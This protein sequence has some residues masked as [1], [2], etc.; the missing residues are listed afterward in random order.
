ME[1]IQKLILQN[2]LSGN[3]SEDQARDMVRVLKQKNAKS[4]EQIAIIGMSV[5][6]PQAK[7]INEYWDMISNKV[8]CVC[9]FPENRRK[10]IDDFLEYQRV[11]ASD[12]KY[13]QMAFLEEIDKF[14]C[15]F[16]K[17][18]PKEAG[19]MDP[20]QRLFLQTAW[21]AVEDAGYGGD[22]LKG[23][24]TGVYV[25]FRGDSDYKRL[26]LDTQPEAFSVAEAGN[27]TSVIASR[28]A[29][30]LDLKG[31]SIVVNTACSSSLVAI[32]CACQGI[33]SGD[34][35]MAIAGAVKIILAPFEYENKL[36]IESSD[37]RTKSFDDS[38]DGTGE[39]EGVASLVLKPLSKALKDG[40]SIY[41]VIKGSAINQD[42]SSNGI[43]APN[44]KAQAEVLKM[45]W[46]D[47]K[48]EPETIAYIEAHGTGTKIGDPIEIDGITSAFRSYTN[49]NGFCAVSSVKTNLGH[50]DTAAGVAGL[51]KAVLALKNKKLPPLSFFNSPNRA[52]NLAESPVYIADKLMDWDTEGYP[53]RC[54][55]S[56]F[57]LSGTN[58]HLVLEEA[59]S[60]KA[61]AVTD[62]LNVLTVSAKSKEALGL[63]I[64]TY[65]EFFRKASIADLRNICYT[66][67][68]GRGHYKY[69]IAMCLDSGESRQDIIDKLESVK[70]D[71]NNGK[72]IF[73][74]EPKNNYP[75]NRDSREAVE[76]D[77][78]K[79]AL[80]LINE[81]VSTG[82]RDRNLLFDICT[83]YTQGAEF[84]WKDLYKGED[85]TKV[86]LPVYPFAQKRCW[87]QIDNAGKNETFK[88]R[89]SYK[90]IDHPL[91]DR[92]LVK[93]IN[94]VIFATDF[95]IDRHWVLSEHS[96][97]GISAVPG[98]TYLEIAVQAAK[99]YYGKEVASVEDVQFYKPLIVGENETVS[100]H[101][102]IREQN[103]EVFF[104]VASCKEGNE[105]DNVGIW[106]L[107][108]T[109]KLSLHKLESPEN[110]NMK[111]LFSRLGVEEA[112]QFD[113]NQK[114]HFGSRWQ[115][116]KSIRSGEEE[117]LVYIE[118][119]QQLI[120]EVDKYMLHPAIL[121]NATALGISSEF[122]YLPFSYKKIEIFKPI[123]A[124][125]YVYIN[126]LPERDGSKEIVTH[127]LS[128][129]NT[130][131]EIVV[132]IHGFTMK[133][134]K[135]ISHTIGKNK[136]KDNLFFKLQWEEEINS[137]AVIEEESK[138]IL[139]IKDGGENAQRILSELRNGQSTIIE[140]DIGTQYHRVNQNLYT[141]GRG[142]DDFAKL[143]R[144]TMGDGVTQILYLS[145]LT[146]NYSEKTNQTDCT[147]LQS[148]LTLFYLTRALVNSKL[149]EALDVVLISGYANKV[150]GEEE[151]IISQNAALFGYGKVV[152]QEYPNL[153]VRCIDID[154]NM[155]AEE[156][157]SEI[158]TGSKNF[159]V[160]YRNGKRYVEIFQPV[161]EAE[162]PERDVVLNKKGVYIITG[163]ISGIGLEIA[164]YL[165]SK[166]NI[167]LALLSRTELPER[168]KW[169]ELVKDKENVK[170]SKKIK[171]LLELESTGANIEYCRADVTN[172]KE[173]SDVINQ[174]R[175]QYTKIN[176]IIHSAG[177]PGAGLIITKNEA[178][179]T[180][181]LA[182]KMIGTYNLDRA[183][184]S[185]ELEFFVLFSSIKSLLGGE[186]Q[187]DYVAANAYLDA[188]TH[189]RNR[190]GKRTL[191]INWPAWKE[192]GM[193][194]DYGVNTDNVFKA[195]S[196]Q[197][198]IEA[199]GKVLM[200]DMER[201]IIGELDYSDPILSS[202]QKMIRMSKSLKL[203]IEQELK[204]KVPVRSSK[205][206]E[207]IHSFVLKGKEDEKY[208][209]LENMVGKIWTEALGLEEINIYDDFYGM[210]G[211]SILAINIVSGIKNLTNYDIN[212]SDFFDN[213]SVYDFARFIETTQ[214][215]D[216]LS[217][218]ELTYDKK[219]LIPITEE[220]EYY[221]VSSG[222]RRMYIMSQVDGETTNYNIPGVNTIEGEL[223]RKH[224][225]EVFK[226][227]IQRHEAFRTT[228]KVIDDEPMQ[229]IH[230]NVDFTIEY[231][232]AQESQVRDVIE[233]FIRPFD[234]KRAPLIRVGLISL[235]KTKHILI[236]DIHHIVFDGSSMRILMEEFFT[237]YNRQKLPE[238]LL[239]Y[240]DFCEWE[241]KLIKSGNI[242]KQEEYWL[243]TFKGT[244]PQ[245]TMPLDYKRARVQTFNGDTINFN[246]SSDIKEKISGL[247]KEQNITLNILFF[248]MFALLINKY[249][250]QKDIVIGSSVAGRPYE[251]LKDIIGMFVNSIAIRINI[252]T[253]S[254]IQEFLK[255]SRDIIV[256]AYDNQSYPFDKLVE[257]LSSKIDRSRNPL[258]DAML[259][260]HNEFDTNTEDGPEDIRFSNYEFSRK[261]STLDFKMDIYPQKE[262]GF[263]CVLEY[264]VDLYKQETMDTFIKHFI[265]LLEDA[266]NNPTKALAEINLFTNEERLLIEQKR[267]NN[268]AEGS[269]SLKLAVSSTF[270]AE[271]ILDYITWWCK[272]FR[273]PVELEFAPYN[274][275]FQELLNDSS[276]ISVNTG[277]NLLLIRFE[278]WIRDDTSED[279][280]KLEKLE[281][282]FRELVQLLENKKKSIPYFVGI[283]PVSTHLSL[284]AELVKHL[285]E[286]NRRW[287]ETLKN[288]KNVYTADFNLAEEIYDIGEIFDK[289]TDKAG[290]IPFT[291]EY[292]AVMGTLVARKIC[293][294]KKQNF[295]V[296]VLD[297][298]NTLWRGICG[299]GTEGE[300]D[301]AE[302][303]RAL[304]SFMLQKRSEG[305]LLALC[306]KNNEKDVWKVFDNNKQMILKQEHFA[307]YRINWKNKS[308]N[309][310][311]MAEELNLGIDSFI[312]IDDN[313]AECAEVM[314][315]CPQ[316][317]TLQLPE[318]QNQIEMY[319]RHVWAFDK[320]KVTKEDRE[321]AQMYTAEKN[322][323]ES[324]KEISSLDDFLE[325]LEIKMSMNIMGEQETDRVS[326]LTQRTNQFNLST[327]RRTEKE[328]TEITLM[329][330]K[331]C[332]VIKVSDRFGDYGLV[333]VV[334]TEEK[335]K[336]LFV[337]TLLLSCRVLGKGIEDSILV[338]LAKECREQGIDIMETEYLF[339]EKNKPV[340]EFLERTGWERAGTTENSIKFRIPIDKIS[341]RAKYVD[342]YFN[343]GYSDVRFVPEEKEVPKSQNRENKEAYIEV[344]ATKERAGKWEVHLVNQEKLL[345]RE[346][347]SPLMKCTV[348][349][350][351]ELPK[352]E[353]VSSNPAKTEYVPPRNKVE[354]EICKIWQTVLNAETV[355]IDDTFFDLGG[356]SL[357][358][359]SLISKIHN[360]F[361]VE[362]FLRDIFSTPTVREM[363]KLVEKLDKSFYSS[364]QPVE[365]KE[366]YALSSAQRRMYIINK[367]EGATTNYNNPGVNVI[368]GELD[369][370]Q[371]EEVFKVLIQRHES[372]RT[373]F[374][375][376]DGEPVQIIHKEADFE[377]EH[378]IAEESEADR[379]IQEFIRPFD[380]ERAPLLRVG[381]V[382]LS[383][384][385]HILICDMHHIISDGVSVNILVNEFIQLL[386]GK[387]LPV[388][389]LHYKD[390]SEWQDKLIKSGNMSKQEEYWHNTFKGTI[391]QL[392]M[393]LDYKRTGVQT[394]NG[395]TINFNISSDIEYKISGLVKEQNITLNIL[396][397]SMFALLINKY[398]SQKDIV[399]GS[400]VAGRPY[401]ELN[402]II[403]MFI[404]S[405]AIRI[406]IDNESNIQEFLKHSR[407]IVV[408]AYDNQSY[409]FDKLVE[410][411]SSK[412]DR[413]RNPLFDA[414][415]IYHNEFDTNTE[416]GPED[417][418]FSNY[419][420]SR[421]TSTL[422]FKMDIY[423]QKEGGF[424]C[425]LEY[426]I[427]LYKQETM[428]T[429]IKHFIMLLED[430]VN[431]PTKA[432]AEMDVFTNEERLLI[433]QKR[434]NNES[435]GSNSLKLAVS[436]TFTAEPISD[437][438]TW[439]CKE[440]R[441]P[442]ELEFAPYNQV[443]QELLNDSSL[444]S[445]NT[446]LNLLLIRFEDWIRDDTSE[447][448]AKLE[449]LE[450]NFR[451]LVQLLENKKKSIPYFVGIFPVSTHLS[452][453]AEL[454]K[455]LE[456]MNRRW[457]KTLKNIKNVYTV[458]FNL[459]EELYDIEEIFDKSTDK[460]GHIPFTDEYFAVMGTMVARKI[461][462]WK[463]QTFKVIVFDC[464]NTLWR[465]ICDEGTETEPY[466]ALQN[467]MLQKRSEGM[468]LALCSKNNEKDVWK[469]F[470]NNEQM[471][472]KQ[473]HFAAYRINLKNKSQ[474][475]MEM[476]EELNLGMDSFIYIDDNPTECAEVMTNCPQV[477][478][479]QLPEN[480]NQIEMYLRHVWA[481]DS[482]KE[483]PKAQNHEYK[484]AS[485][486]AA[487][488][489]RRGA[490]KWE[491]H[492]VNEEKLLHREYMSPLMKCT[493]KELLEL[494]KYERMSSNPAKTEYVPPRN[495]VEE[496]ICKIW[497]IVLNLETV[498]IDDT[499][500]DLGGN[501]L[502]AI[503]LEVEMEKAGFKIAGYDVF[504]LK[505]VR[506][507][508]AQ[509][510]SD[511]VNGTEIK[512][513]DNMSNTLQIVSEVASQEILSNRV[514]IDGIKP[515][516]EIYYKNCFYNSAF[517]VIE[518][519]GR[520]INTF[521]IND[522]PVFSYDEDSTEMK[523]D[524]EYIQVKHI[525]K[526]L[527]EEGIM[528]E[529]KDS[530]ENIVKD[531]IKSIS[532]KRPVVIW[533]D[534]F[535]ESIRPEMYQK[536]HWPHTLLVYGYDESQKVFYII[537]HE[538]RDN[539]SYKPRT[540]G[541]E[542]IINSYNGYLTNFS[543]NDATYYEFYY[544]SAI[545]QEKTDKDSRYLYLSYITANKDLIKEHLDYLNK[546][547]LDLEKI[548]L[549][550]SVLD[551]SI[552]WL[553]DGINNIVNIK[554]VEKY[555]ITNLFGSESEC[556]STFE[557]I[558]SNWIFT[559]GAVAK[560]MY[561]GVYKQ[562]AFRSLIQSVS[563]FYE[564]E[565]KYYTVLFQMGK[566]L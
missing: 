312:F 542:D 407:D 101:T 156:L 214:S 100:A 394:F 501:S 217:S 138:T 363:A 467:F 485:V 378:I 70:L 268:E 415:L 528:V 351:L 342:C 197:E 285:E 175:T 431:N 297:C 10:D 496:E 65:I 315:N 466:I 347:M 275:V 24:K 94:E 7:D 180:K 38:S 53:R 190:L 215:S 544:N 352:Y 556:C 529:T 76:S 550:K 44:P 381:L 84:D 289:S 487:S 116:M 21:N 284:S 406:D 461:C 2:V 425:V 530:S 561:S 359:V 192:T 452:L 307:A 179:I 13:R 506:Q 246:I 257:K 457:K 294:W 358:A 51:V 43:T 185:D 465:G 245:L 456:E 552:Q 494:P 157:F 441:E 525:E 403:G 121:D 536:S 345:H 329:S 438:I 206:K 82:K 509:F 446:G 109:G 193:A 483:V 532:K 118:P 27:L 216:I 383:D 208:T 72:G 83:L 71:E 322:R 60:A 48:I 430:A 484:V 247:V 258:F 79:R 125:S 194:A 368:T 147:S 369:K 282:N 224:L 526:L 440:F 230:K 263:S 23:T 86:N 267:K 91:L 219:L 553:L 449:K 343:S 209:E 143:I 563:K 469:V 151:A 145:K 559:R 419:E 464:D 308:Q 158:N 324:K 478:T 92:C 127:N 252:D 183:T 283:F 129:I 9:Q 122:F 47:A 409:P 64:D 414:M 52:L 288:I 538:H 300:V 166:E 12:I 162:I 40:D 376:V 398:S 404:N 508:A 444:I 432:L 463:K 344:A 95:N 155:T 491:V 372:F 182:S 502:L 8:N 321:R 124:K 395:D 429:F 205:A 126:Q 160:S 531:I 448:G 25:G 232:D 225:E 270:T 199:F 212:I 107:H 75:H 210:G 198:G 164:K 523:L 311:E 62:F 234:L 149:T 1:R 89:E 510:T 144:D 42:G 254:K 59:P 172:Y 445:V 367:M 389:L 211:D 334:I 360:S 524:V 399:I 135:D 405:I 350:L 37:A 74:G 61:N 29:Y 420:F 374:K 458:D 332:Y 546:F 560:Y 423:P 106:N 201:V 435:Q 564:L 287:K 293:A 108:A 540:I 81:F 443:F 238:L 265:M 547:T 115:C 18:S 279:G 488:A 346:Y 213:P 195:I 562:Q 477:L 102:C 259:I 377:I 187:S 159:L 262:G 489:I 373:S 278:D 379:V 34:C 117:V 250:S 114:M 68:T 292:F 460:A 304:Q 504:K 565:S 498:G 396:F 6:F 277:L 318:N 313:P 459:A 33:R 19:L 50:L 302:P 534:C 309:I 57:G 202:E 167:N 243:N 535:Y 233:E 231:I 455:H 66:S 380:L 171:A 63:L 28:I 515:F 480:Q 32:H 200:S 134:V 30:I 503:K 410:K 15:E 442:V 375:V 222:Q 241:N 514:L 365:E 153:K 417:I 296:I 412:I 77:T 274:Q 533:I 497:Q 78:L 226:V 492:V 221:H 402:D 490:E 325:G 427:D 36:G 26:I 520:S 251:E 527:E 518:L 337:E 470:D 512:T 439:W 434:K 335:G 130:E 112:F 331:K 336:S 120:D 244:I 387:S 306:S 411:L 67:N 385:K 450:R 154:D 357:K 104:S 176:G 56:S 133:K 301:V 49:K 261:T 271:P 88:T 14:D 354:E 401:E 500:F 422:D 137:G 391:P 393:P 123:P 397:F 537:E 468:L 132:K 163:G 103:G 204:K 356:N 236:H 203:Q 421:K 256:A 5:K 386:N 161:I 362:L 323:Q 80:T 388:P 119:M 299:E 426:N 141:V 11:D 111:E 85:N 35:D 186:G 260:Y 54:G 364:I 303:Y 511:N 229:V 181:V 69:R 177:V 16:F 517:P 174:L 99:Y 482:L 4:E 269:N 545:A 330:N 189:Y 240:K 507:L 173:V 165:S 519:Y 413:S 341:A 428:D 20:N 220:K 140:A 17:I 320:L 505:T 566:E 150:T 314:T 264:N 97:G 96:I 361:S 462:A 555:L 495:K 437:Y 390:Y 310:K 513:E 39:G 242:S 392:T 551:M 384:Q 339:T 328:I 348:K 93:T 3:L 305:M 416:D 169:D 481:F 237:L 371:L 298:D 73:Y 473:E 539:L 454:V 476:A 45:A 522:V 58:C 46:K 493:V 110:V 281:R 326:Q 474:N 90:E 272:E 249:S 316:V 228:F 453:S 207:Q 31:P 142:E 191:T 295:K 239:Q 475:I 548:V 273:E 541:F 353:N 136:A 327:I 188:Y 418:R 521:L 471:I 218:S 235:S 22:R 113:Y 338:G 87:L 280:A 317:L 340:L 424:S 333:G 276:L 408:A 400:S 170:L 451:E 370:V 266:V 472:L 433:E 255:Y 41:A 479:L 549:D 355:G 227:L 253:E 291:D 499:F 146:C 436:S 382:E 98:T 557:E 290:H 168:N 486:K 248:S 447:D 196:T 558:F 131:G 128:I 105:T 554:Q 184:E 148:I 319:L 286:M 55:V 178:Q 366:Y 516:N 543:T 139:V 349:E 152:G 223:D